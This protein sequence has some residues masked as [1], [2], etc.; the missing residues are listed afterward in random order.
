MSEVTTA[1]TTALT[2]IKGD[3]VSIMGAVAAGGLAIFGIKFAASQ[4]MAF[5]KKIAK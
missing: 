5:F 3:V 2:S 4:G 1:I